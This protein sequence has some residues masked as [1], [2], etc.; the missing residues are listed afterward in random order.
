LLEL[1]TRNYTLEEEAKK[2]KHGKIAT[3]YTG[4]GTVILKNP[5]GLGSSVS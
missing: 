5:S 3:M 1:K 4:T 2:S